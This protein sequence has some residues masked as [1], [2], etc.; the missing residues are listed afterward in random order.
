MPPFLDLDAMARTLS[1]EQFEL[2]L[3][4]RV[5]I[6]FDRLSPETREISFNIW[7]DY[8]ES[9]RIK[10]ATWRVGSYDTNTKGEI[11]AD[12][13]QEHNRRLSFEESCTLRLLETP[14]EAVSEATPAAS[15]ADDDVP[16]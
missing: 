1:A 9:R 2:L 11:L 8:G 12:C 14:V 4:A 16:F 6:E 3:R 5:Q 15:S 7:C 13:I 10:A